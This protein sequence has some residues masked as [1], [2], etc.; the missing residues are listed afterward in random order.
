MQNLILFKNLKIEKWAR[1]AIGS[2]K[3]TAWNLNMDKNININKKNEKGKLIVRW[4]RKGLGSF[5][6]DCL[7]CHKEQS[8]DRKFEWKVTG[9][10]YAK[11]NII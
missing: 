3:E 9:N 10:S 1:K 2:L 5:K 11:F 8:N 4:G 6:K 7:A